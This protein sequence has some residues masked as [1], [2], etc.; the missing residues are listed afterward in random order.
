MNDTALVSIIVAGLTFGAP[1]VYVAMGE[2]VSQRAGVMNLSLDGIMLVSAVSGYSVAAETGSLWLALAVSIGVGSLMSATFAM[3]T[4]TLRASQVLAGLGL[5]VFGTGMSQYLGRIGD[6]PLIGRLAHVSIE[7]YTTGGLTNVPLLGPILFGHDFIIYGS[8]LL[9]ALTYFYLNHT[10]PGL[11]IRAVGN[12]PSSAEAAGVRVA[13]VRAVHV[14]IGGGLA[15]LGGAY[16]SL[17]LTT[18]WQ[19]RITG[20]AGWL[21]I[22][23]VIGSRWQPVPAF[24]A[25]FIFGASIR[26]GFTLQVVGTNVP[27]ELL[28]MLPYILAIVAILLT[29]VSPSRGLTEPKALGI[30][31]FR[32]QR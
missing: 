12:D 17:G 23:I 20:G 25:A 9:V 22:A 8:W 19:E 14:I 28:N 26:L 11:S 6:D 18:I 13:R 15:G 7:P 2:L 5:L 32:E 29:A 27:P 30:P 1:L 31:F 10:E 3:L 21:V 4:I 16:Y 24:L